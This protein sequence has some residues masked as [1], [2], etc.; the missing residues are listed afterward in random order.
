MA[1]RAEKMKKWLAIVV[2]TGILFGLAEGRSFADDSESGAGKA[3]YE[4]DRYDF[5]FVW[6]S[7]TQYYSKTFHRY[8]R[9]NVAWIRDNRD[10]LKIRYVMHTGD[11]VDEGDKIGQWIEADRNMKVLDDTGI[12]YGVLA[13]NHDAGRIS[14]YDLYRRGFGE[15]RF[16]HRPTYGG[17]YQNNRGHFDLLS[18]A[19]HDFIIV[20]MSWSFGDAEIAW[21]NQVLKRYPN[22][23]AMLC[24]H[25]YLLVSG[26]RS[27]IGDR[28]FE[29]VVLPNKNVFAILSG[30]HHDAEIKIDPVDDDG[31]GKADRSVYQM[32]ADY[33][34]AVDGG[35][36]YIRLLQFDARSGKLHVKT[37]SPT[38]NDYN[39]Y[40]P[41]AYP[42]K[43]E[44]TL[45]LNPDLTPTAASVTTD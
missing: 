22:R 33:Q 42:G 24:F 1:I 27:P 5:S 45:D 18:A 10:K 15:D 38:L 39:Y 26:E 8:F 43:D 36:G 6:M 25:E 44:F 17:S 23:K 12:P 37:Y 3:D 40:D 32:M 28:V 35:L 29:S 41:I 20:Y 9:D 13:G 21:M 19:G 16:K 4:A 14:G 31:D 7:D 34:N 11:I 2:I 30:H